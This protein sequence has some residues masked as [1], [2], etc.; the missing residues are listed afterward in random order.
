MMNFKIG[1]Q[2]RIRGNLPG[3]SGECGKIVDKLSHSNYDYKL[4]M[5]DGF[6][7]LSV[8]AS[9][10]EKVGMKSQLHTFD[11]D[12]NPVV[13]D[14]S[15]ETVENLRNAFSHNIPE[16]LT[17]GM[18]FKIRGSEDLRML[19]AFMEDVFGFVRVSYDNEG[20]YSI[21]L[22]DNMFSRTYSSVKEI[23]DLLIKNGA[24]YVCKFE[25]LCWIRKP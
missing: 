4:N 16:S 20:T 23:R 8:Y 1:D 3:W 9:E 7:G 5:N 25:D 12:G 17:A 10:I 6:K 11:N 13:I 2:V 15:E 19:Y 24:K 14:I 18:V 22:C 21:E